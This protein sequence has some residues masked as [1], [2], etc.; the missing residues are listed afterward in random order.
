MSDLKSVLGFFI[1]L[2]VFILLVAFALGRIKLPKNTALKNIF[3]AKKTAKTSP[4]PTPNKVQT[5]S[6]IT[7]NSVNQELKQALQ[8]TLITTTKGGL[9]VNKIKGITT[10]PETGAPTALIP[11]SLLLGSAGFYLRRKK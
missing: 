4:T 5:D 2:V 3:S 6:Q 10:I 11:F 1:G 7:T 8:P 9:P